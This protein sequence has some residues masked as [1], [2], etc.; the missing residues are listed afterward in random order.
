MILHLITTVQIIAAAIIILVLVS[1]CGVQNI[2]FIPWEL[3][4]SWAC[5]FAQATETHKWISNK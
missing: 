2:H 4:T 1:V 3:K 5:C